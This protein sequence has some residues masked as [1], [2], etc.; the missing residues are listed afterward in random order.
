[1]SL[2]CTIH[3]PGLQPLLSPQVCSDILIEFKY[4]RR[5]FILV[6]ITSSVQDDVKVAMGITM[7][8]LLWAVKMIS[9]RLEKCE[10][11]PMV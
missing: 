8:H 5:N 9:N 3:C 4:G 11:K 6:T 7:Q 1:M 2:S 10:E